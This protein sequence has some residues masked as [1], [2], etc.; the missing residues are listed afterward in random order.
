MRI[1]Y[2]L[3]ELFIIT[4]GPCMPFDIVDVN[5]LFYS[6]FVTNDN[7]FRRVIIEIRY[8][9]KKRRAKCFKK[10]L[11]YIQLHIYI[12]CNKVSLLYKK[13][14]KTITRMINFQIKNS[15]KRYKSSDVLNLSNS[16]LARAMDNCGH[17]PSIST[18]KY[19]HLKQFFSTN[20]LC[21]L[22][23]GVS[24]LISQRRVNYQQNYSTNGI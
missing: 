24:T 14:V 23:C 4:N 11:L 17:Q 2:I 19:L 15:C 9:P 1:R 6:I 16:V 7:W 20:C 5:L 21:L 13:A 8:L 3:E 10:M 22:F 12:V 18:A